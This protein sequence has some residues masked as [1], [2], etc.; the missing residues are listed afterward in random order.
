MF[1]HNK[2]VRDRIPE[3]IEANGLRSTTRILDDDEYAVLLNAKLTEELSEFLTSGEI[4]ELADLVEIVQA[5]A[6]S[7]GLSWSEFEALRFAKSE[8]K[9]GF[10]GRMFLEAVEPLG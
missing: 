3:I 7:R 2:L 10:E 4:E 9:G 6:V 5:I 8:T 1:E